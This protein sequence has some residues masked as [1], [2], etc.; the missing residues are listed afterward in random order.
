MVPSCHVT[1]GRVEVGEVGDAVLHARGCEHLRDQPERSAVRVVGEQHAVAG[2]EQ[3]QHRVLRGHAAREREAGGR[4]FEG[5]DARFVH[6]ARGIAAA[7]VLEA[8]VFA[9]RALRERRRQVDRRHHRAGLRVGILPDVDGA[10][11]E[12][13]ARFAVGTT[14]I[15]VPARP[16]T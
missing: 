7:R 2:R 9:D 15:A 5:R 4:A 13:V 3:P 10:G 6:G 11:L 8:G 12:A 1:R 16:G 14:V